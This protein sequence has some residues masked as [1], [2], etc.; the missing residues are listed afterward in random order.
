M[1][2]N[3]SMDIFYTRCTECTVFLDVVLKSNNYCW[4][5]KQANKPFWN[6]IWSFYFRWKISIHK[7]FFFLEP[8]C[9]GLRTSVT[10]A[11]TN[12]LNSTLQNSNAEIEFPQY[13]NSSQKLQDS[14]VRCV[15]QNK[16]MWSKFHA[17][18]TEMIITKAGR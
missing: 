16:E 9:V 8:D 15:L 11:N 6:C 3:I 13:G 18:G 12:Y 7:T 4:S 14:N 1:Y 17:V 5:L 2:I 10:D